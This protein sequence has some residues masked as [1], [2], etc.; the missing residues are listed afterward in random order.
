MAR[1]QVEKVPVQ[2]PQSQFVDSQTSNAPSACSATP[3]SPTVQG[4]ATSPTAV[5]PIADSNIQHTM[6]S[7]LSTSPVVASPVTHADGIQT[8]ARTMEETAGDNPVIV[9]DAEAM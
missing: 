7:T 4:V 1:E 6:V 3:S 5:V 9:A 2:E 8:I